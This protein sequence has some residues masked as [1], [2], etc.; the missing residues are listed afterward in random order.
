MEIQKLTVAEKITLA[1]A[2]WDSVAEQEMDLAL[3]IEQKQALDSRLA[4]FEI[5]GQYGDSWS[6]VKARILSK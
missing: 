2:L 1:E 4:S 5:D 3:T 6:Q